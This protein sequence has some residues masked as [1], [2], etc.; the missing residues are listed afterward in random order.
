[1]TLQ[2]YLIYPVAVEDLDLHYNP[3]LF[4]YRLLPMYFF[5]EYSHHIGFYQMINYPLM[6]WWIETI[7]QCWE[8]ELEIQ[9]LMKG[10]S[11]YTT[12]DNAEVTLRHAVVVVP[13]ST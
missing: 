8:Y 7:I 2:T 5:V 1:M 11:C 3:S 6:I 13:V 12:H 10:E 4:L 9:T